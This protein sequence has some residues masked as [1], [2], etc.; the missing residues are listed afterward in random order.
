MATLRKLLGV[1]SRQTTDNTSVHK[2]KKH[3]TKGKFGDEILIA[4]EGL[5]MFL[6]VALRLIVWV[7]PVKLGPDSPIFV[8]RGGK[9]APLTTFMRVRDGW[10]FCC[11]V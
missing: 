10:V 7:H 4:D 8:T 9:K 6:L 5:S 2:N 11:G 1:K 3:K